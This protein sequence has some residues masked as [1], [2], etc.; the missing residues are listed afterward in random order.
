ML[1]S[2]FIWSTQHERP[3]RK[4]LEDPRR[5]LHDLFNHRGYSLDFW[6]YLAYNTIS[7]KRAKASIKKIGA[8]APE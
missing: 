3:K 2:G 4:N 8:A 6:Y 7:K 5:G 1:K